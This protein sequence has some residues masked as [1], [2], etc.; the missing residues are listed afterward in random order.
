LEG[1]GVLLS[2]FEFVV[3]LRTALVTQGHEENKAQVTS[4]EQQEKVS[5]EQEE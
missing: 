3:C 5:E 1:S 4:Q 2:P